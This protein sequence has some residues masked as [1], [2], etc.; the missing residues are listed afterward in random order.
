MLAIASDA[1]Q[2]KVPGM[3]D[4]LAAG[5][6]TVEAVTAAD[7]EPSS[8]ELAVAGRSRPAA[9]ARRNRIVADAAELVSALR[10]D[11]LL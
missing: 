3:K 8:V 6:K 4:I 11:G 2:V 7:L 10:A 5:R 1:A 9:R